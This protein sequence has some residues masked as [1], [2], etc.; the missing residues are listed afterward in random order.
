MMDIIAQ[1][2]FQTEINW[3][4]NP[5]PEGLKLGLLWEKHLLVDT[6]VDR[7]E[8]ELM[9][10]IDGDG[11]PEFIVNSW[12]KETSLLALGS[13]LRDTRSFDSERQSHDRNAGS[14]FRLQNHYW[15]QQEWS[16]PG[17]RRSQ[18]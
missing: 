1:S 12:N 18:R 7:N 11:V 9:E 5:G 16:R 14:S 3:F 2:F 15:L 17:H 4:R 13:S 6:K 8:A 10:D